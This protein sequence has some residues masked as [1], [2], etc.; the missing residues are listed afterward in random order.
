MAY[1]IKETVLQYRN[2]LTALRRH[3]HENPELSKKEFQTMAYIESYLTNLGIP[4]HHVDKGGIIAWIDGK[5]PGKTI[6]LRADIDALPIEE[7]ETN[8]SCK[9]VCRSHTKGV[10]H[11][12]GHDGHMAMLLVAAKILQQWKDQFD[13]KVVL[14]FEQGEEE[15]GPLAYLLKYLKRD[16]GLHIDA[17]YATHVRWDVPAG[18]I[19]ICH[20]APMAGGFG[21]EIKITG[22]GGHGSRPDLAQSPIDCFHAFYSDL[23]AL[24]MRAVSPRECL[25]V[26][27][28]KLQS[29]TTLNVIPND[30]TFAGTCRFFSYDKAG[31]R[32]YEEFLQ[33][34]DSRCKD[35][36]CTYE[37][38][39]MPKP[40]YEVQNNPACVALAEN[41]VKKYIGPDALYTCEPWMASESF[42]IT[43]RL[44]PGVLIFTG[45]ENLEK[46]CG[47]NHHTAE[48]DM[49]EAGLAYGAMT[50]LGYTLDFLQEK[51]DLPFVEDDEPLD[52]LVSRN[53]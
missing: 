36:G 23:Q 28:G 8:L 4:F 15:S 44:Y 7:K 40:L 45:I 50:C 19:A 2:E 13:G 38:L 10:M 42:A 34:L 24:R 16:S 46:G 25:T 47:A 14:M 1:P 33:L 17:C 35:Y 9:R 6:L 21:F 18:K 53:I 29:G 49:D 48:F 52:D 37:I 51:P 5:G 26:S 3:F 31:K 39:H 32:F 30:L 11:A 43:T 12:C 22:H 20:E 27:L 41:A